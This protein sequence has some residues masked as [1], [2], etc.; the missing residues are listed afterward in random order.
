MTVK[1][2]TVVF[3][4]PDGAGKTTLLTLVKSELAAR[5]VDFA[6]YYFS[7][8]YLKRYRSSGT[9]KTT[10]N[11]HE[12]RQYSAGLVSLKILLMLFEFNMGLPRVKRR[13][14]LVL[15]DRFI[16]DLLVDPRRYR[17]N[18][19]R[20]WM[21][22]LLKLSPRVDLGV[23]IVAPPDVIQERKQEV[24]REETER[25]IAAYRNA[26]GLFLRAIVVEN[27]GP[28]EM[29]AKKIVEEIRQR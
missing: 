3:L 25:Q 20:W 29:A 2:R 22:A 7:P 23:I 18:R 17:M 15:F 19:V 10:N 14:D 5:G 13:N 28:P 24:T 27:I 11:P 4:G 1:T 26:T 21:R 12:G 16:L 6:H 9:P 8:G